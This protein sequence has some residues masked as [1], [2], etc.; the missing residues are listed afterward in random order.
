MQPVNDHHALIAYREKPLAGPDA[1]FDSADAGPAAAEPRL[2]LKGRRLLGRGARKADPAPSRLSYRFQRWMLT[3]GIRLGLRIG[4]PFCLAL[5]A[6]GIFFADQ[7]RRD[8]LNIFVSDIRTSI[9]ERPEFMVNLMAVDGAGPG[10]SEDIREVVPLDFP[11]SSFDLDVDQVRDT[12]SGLDPVKSASVRIK[13]GGILQ[14]D[15]VERQPVVVWRTQDGIELL[16]ETGAHVADLASRADR[17]DLPLIAGDGADEHVGEALALMRAARGLGDRVRGVVRIGDR[18][19]DL[20]LDR[21]Q[22]IML[23]TER[24]VQALERVL[25]VSEVQD[26]LERDVAVV[27]MRLGMRP[28]I[29]MTEAAS[30]E[31]W[32]TRMTKTGNGQ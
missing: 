22:R 25:A 19:W 24:P 18:R 7:K 4:V 16:D 12:I 28:T 1:E 11:I 13:P 27:D 2:R 29:R 15:V 8:A 20:V 5:L 9:Q 31:W 6:G 10:L 14:V 17:P 23:P 26:L 30:E 32:S 3:P 21:R